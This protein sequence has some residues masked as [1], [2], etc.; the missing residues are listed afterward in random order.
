MYYRTGTD[1]R[2]CI[3]A[4][5]TLRFHSQGGST[6]LSRLKWCHGGNGSN[7]FCHSDL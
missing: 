7:G 4:R 6:T 5:K 3:W 2:C 1:G